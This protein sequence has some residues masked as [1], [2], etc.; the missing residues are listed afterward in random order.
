M[1]IY[2]GQSLVGKEYA[3]YKALRDAGLDPF[4]KLKNLNKK[5]RRI[6][7]DSVDADLSEPTPAVRDATGR[8]FL[9]DGHHTVF[10]AALLQP[11]FNKLRIQVELVYDAF[12]TNMEWNTF[13]NLALQENWFYAPTAKEILERP[14]HVH[15]LANNVER[16]MLGLFFT[17]IEDAFKVPMKG[18]HFTS[19]IQFYLADLIRTEQVYTFA[20]EVDF[21]SVPALQNTLLSNQKIVD[22]LIAQLRPEAPPELR[23]FLE[24][25]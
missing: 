17:S 9:L 8:I 16:S 4:L 10:V 20:S 7:Q 12:K 24:N 18:K 22:F 1:Q 15:E 6:L 25:L 19:F 13:V 5:Q 3:I 23:T 21:Q 14:L 2:A 11:Q